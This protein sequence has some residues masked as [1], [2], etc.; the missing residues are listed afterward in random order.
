VSAFSRTECPKSQEYAWDDNASKELNIRFFNPHAEDSENSLFL[1]QEQINCLREM[2]AHLTA[3]ELH[4]TK[5]NAISRE[6]ESLLDHA[7][8]DIKK[9][10]YSLNEAIE[11]K[12][13]AIQFIEKASSDLK[14]V[15]ISSVVDIT[16]D[17]TDKEEFSQVSSKIEKKSLLKI[18]KI[19]KAAAISIIFPHFAPY[20]VAKVLIDLSMDA[21]IGED[22][23]NNTAFIIKSFLNGGVEIENMMDI[24]FD[25]ID[26]K[27]EINQI[28][29]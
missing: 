19:G 7:N 1:F 21:T 9:S 13:E 3:I 5:I 20:V 17:E 24:G 27:D 23:S 11:N 25:K 28:E 2:D 16:S 29:N 10:Y 14:K 26:I 18:L 15:S 22:E 4:L 12:H 6:I 8:T